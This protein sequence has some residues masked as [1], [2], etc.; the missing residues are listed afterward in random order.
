[1]TSSL[2]RT[3][4]FALLCCTQLAGPAQADAP[5]TVM[6]KDL[7][8]E[9]RAESPFAKLTKPQLQTLSDIAEARDRLSNGEKLNAIELEDERAA[10]RKLEKAGID[11]DGLLHKRKEMMDQKAANNRAV[12]A[13]L[14]GKM[15]RI[16]GYV[17]PLEF[18][19]KEVTEF[20]LV[21]W[22][23]ACIHTPPPP[24]N[25]IVHV[26]PDKPFVTSGLFA[27]VWVTGRLSANAAQK[28][29]TLVDGTSNVD[30]GY[31][32]QANV[33]EPYKEE[34]K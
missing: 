12:N 24:A 18:K 19:G 28:S 29:L 7:V 16:P 34:G 6:W 32:I 2:L 20:L 25:Q 8:P 11:V 21:P 10:T 1:M 31:A 3:A 4:F 23:G 27:P 9:T 26:K 5:R 17:L 15:V 22:V 13:A 14:D 30:V 33:V